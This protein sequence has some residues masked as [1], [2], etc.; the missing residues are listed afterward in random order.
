M[1][2]ARSSVAAAILVGASF[3]GCAQ[4]EKLDAQR[5]GTEPTPAELLRTA[6]TWKLAR[7]LK[8]SV[9]RIPRLSDGI[10]DRI[11]LEGSPNY[12]GHFEGLDRIVQVRTVLARSQTL[13]AEL[14]NRC[15]RFTIG[16]EDVAAFDHDSY[17]RAPRDFRV[18]S[19]QSEDL[20]TAN[21]RCVDL[22]NGLED[23]IHM[24]AWH[25]FNGSNQALA[26][27]VAL[28][29]QL[30]KADEAAAEMESTCRKFTPVAP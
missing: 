1:N 22:V 30:S 24:E 4:K 7:E 13:A 19:A 16:G 12:V 21:A 14:E 9:D 26:R 29:R 3:L 5:A 27:V 25:S 28:R 23:R 15:K 10:V 2:A 20:S 11:A 17:L 8:E 6:D 18:L